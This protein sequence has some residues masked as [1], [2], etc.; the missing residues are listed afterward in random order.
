MQINYLTWENLWTLRF[1]NY[2]CVSKSMGK[3]RVN[4]KSK[5]YLNSYEGT[6]FQTKKDRTKEE[7]KQKLK[8]F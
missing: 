8:L 2:Y 7:Q 5:S 4:H 1:G 3:I 6:Q